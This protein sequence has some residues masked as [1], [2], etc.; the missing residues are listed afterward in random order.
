M[1]PPPPMGNPI[2]EQGVQLIRDV[3]TGPTEMHPKHRNQKRA[4]NEYMDHAD[5]QAEHLREEGPE[6]DR[7][8]CG[9][10]DHNGFRPDQ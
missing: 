3:H 4:E 10:A 6:A 9:C 7:T 2:E 5:V 8:E 1:L